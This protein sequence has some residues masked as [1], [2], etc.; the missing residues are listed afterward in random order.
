LFK[1][2]KNFVN[3]YKQEAKT[4]KTLFSSISVVFY[5]AKTT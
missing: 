3:F 5:A 1:R 4:R 2:S